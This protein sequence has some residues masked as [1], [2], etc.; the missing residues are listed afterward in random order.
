M[1]IR[2]CTAADEAALFALI[3]EEGDE[4]K[5]YWGA[6]GMENY[7]RALRNSV[8]YAAYDGAELCG[9]ARCRDDDGFGL[10]VYDLLVRQS[11]R[12]S[13]LGRALM[14]R[15]AADYPGASTYVMGDVP[16]YYEGHL[17]YAPEGS[18]YIVSEK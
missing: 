2:R 4:W 1:E 14:E 6:E 17:G 13:G 9:Y 15:A 8:V 18:I 16:G 3:R 5:D 11:R 10:Y 7:R 12:G